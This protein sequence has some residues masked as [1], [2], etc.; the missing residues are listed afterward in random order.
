MALN[1][2]D[3][4]TD[5]LARELAK[6]TGQ[7]ITQAVAAALEEK[8]QAKRRRRGKKIDRDEV[9]RLAREIASAP[10]LDPA[11]PRRSWATTNA[12]C[13]A[14]GYRYFGAAGDRLSGAEVSSLMDMLDSAHPRLI[15]AAS[16]VE[17]RILAKSGP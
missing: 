5:R 11:H 2:K 12:D 7:S 6:L 14:D 10:V 9:M 8:L 3:G 13:R 16:V 1:I 17:A 4:R 15:S